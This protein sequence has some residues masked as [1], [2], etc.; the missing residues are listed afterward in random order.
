MKTQILV[1]GVEEAGLRGES[2]GPEVDVGSFVTESAGDAPPD[3][4]MKNKV[5]L[6]NLVACN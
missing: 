1:M 3:A 5:F 4:M 6:A 2:A